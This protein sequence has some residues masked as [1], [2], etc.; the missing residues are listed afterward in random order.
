[1]AIFL[2]SQ[3]RHFG[4]CPNHAVAGMIFNRNRLILPKTLQNFEYGKNEVNYG[5]PDSDHD[6]TPSSALEQGK[7]I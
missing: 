7:N 2:V 1:L 3:P 4:E 5:F 6:A